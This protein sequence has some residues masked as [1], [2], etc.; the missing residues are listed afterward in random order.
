MPRRKTHEEY[1]KG[2][3]EINPDIEVVDRYINDNTKIKHRCKRDG[4]EWY[5]KPNHILQGRG[6]P[7]CCN[8]IPYTLESFKSALFVVNN[9]MEVIDEKYINNKTPILVKCKIDGHIW[10]TTPNALLKGANCPVCA[11][12]TI[13][14]APEYKNS[15]WSSQYRD[16]FSK[17]LS[18]EQMKKYMPNS[19]KKDWATCPDCGK[20]K[21]IIIEQLL[22]QGIGCMCGDGQSFPNKFVYNIL[23]QLN[24]N[25]K[26]EYVP[27]W[28]KKIRYDDYL[29]DYNLIIENHGGQHYEKCNLTRRTLFEEQQNDKIKQ[30]FA[31]TNGIKYYV[32]IDC[33]KSSLDWIK[34]SIM[35]SILPQ[36]L[37]FTENDIDWNQA[38][39]YATSNLIK[40]SAYLFND[41]KTISEISNLLCVAKPTVA[42]WLKT[43]TSF[44]WCN[45][46]PKNKTRT[47]YCVE[48]NKIFNSIKSAS[49]ELGIW[50]TSIIN[51]LRGRWK[52]TIVPNT[53]EKLHWLYIEDMINI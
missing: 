2:V 43:A 8:H 18:E 21:Y 30:N 29:P 10:R 48:L 45:Y 14:R 38:N 6:C 7:K 22:Y 26:P 39:E 44:G 51:C 46:I 36:I 13:G 47:I 5:A 33:R 24:I 27:P 28:N 3:A 11:G 15:I 52:Y 53:K 49:D 31:L 32:V 20:Q 35:N 34:T 41:G 1:V 25:V 16:Y 9:A 19:C 42:R 4:Y 37:N 12:K 40:K 50:E 17:F 23:T